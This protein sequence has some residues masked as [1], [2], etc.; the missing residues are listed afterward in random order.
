MKEEVGVCVIY[1]RT[2]PL[3]PTAALFVKQIVFTDPSL[4]QRWIERVQELKEWQQ[5]QRCT[6]EPVLFD[7]QLV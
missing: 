5:S 1:G 4:A 7:P 6:P 2:R 3:P